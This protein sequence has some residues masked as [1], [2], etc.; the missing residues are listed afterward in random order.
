MAATELIKKT[1]RPSMQVGQVY[2]RRY[3][4]TDPLAEVGNVLELAIEHGEDVVR[5]DDMSRMGGG[6]H[7]EVRR[8]NEVNVSMKLADVNIVNLARATLGSISGVDAGNVANESHTARRGGLIRLA[9]I[10]ATNV[11]LRV[12]AGAPATV[13]DE[14]YLNVQPN[15]QITLA[16]TTVSNI[17]VKSGASWG[18][19]TPL[20]QA[21]NY[22]VSGNEITIDAS[23]ASFTGGH[24]IWVTY[25]YTDPAGTLVSAAGNYEP[26]PEGVF[27]LADAA[28]IADEGIVSI[29]YDYGDQAVIEALTAKSV[30]LELVFGGLNEADGGSPC[31]VEVFRASQSVTQQLALINSS[32]GALDVS[33]SILIDPTKTGVGISRYYKQTIAAAS[34]A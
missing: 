24:G 7:A 15:D 20:A 16:Q 28:D 1:Y 29:S 27:V 6:V 33:G 32:F 10:G 8:V 31:V 22:T 5:Q 2:A 12:G 18:T 14:E 23:P 4:T 13:E 26:R 9:H 30:E 25:D 17:S 19:A 34:A 11:Q 3:G 21:G